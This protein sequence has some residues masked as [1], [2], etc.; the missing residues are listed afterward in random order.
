MSDKRLVALATAALMLSVVAVAVPASAS[1]NPSPTTALVSRS[2]AGK[3]GNHPS[4]EPSISADGR[5]VA[6]SSH[7]TNLVPG[8]TNQRIDIFVRDLFTGHVV[9]ASVGPGGV[10]TNQPSGQPRISG[11]GRYVAFS[12]GADNLVAGDNNN[13]PDVFVRDLKAG[14]T[15]LVSVGIGGA[16]ANGDNAAPTLS[17]DGRYI[18]FISSAS[19]LVAG[20]TN[21]TADVFVRDM[22]A[23]VTTRISVATGGGQ[24]NGFSDGPSMSADGRFVAFASGAT[25]LVS[26]DT[27]GFID[28]FLRDRTAATTKRI[29]LGAGGVQA[30][31]PVSQAAISANGKYVAFVSEA[32]NLVATDTDTNGDVVRRS[33]VTGTNTQVSFRTDNLPGSFATEP[34]ISANGNLVAFTT[35]SD[36]VPADTNSNQDV[37]LRNVSAGTNELISVDQSGGGAGLDTA[38]ASISA[39]GHRVVFTSSV[40]TLVVGDTNNTQDVFVRCR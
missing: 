27:N 2:A 14:V 32:S 1:A 34:A 38:N 15:R 30:N 16:R 12:S 10:Q 26:G 23:G 35:A 21:G 33:L 7:A 17:A 5:Y 6:F 28:I 37:Y 4:A 8:D 11:N 20:D 25:N 19:N 3:V 18:A 13:Q 24:S 22:Q 31:G 36:L 40:A 39:E 29:S 9:R